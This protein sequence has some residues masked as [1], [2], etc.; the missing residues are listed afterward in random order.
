MANELRSG[1]RRR[2]VMGLAGLL[3]PA[4]AAPLF[5]GVSVVREVMPVAK[6]QGGEWEEL[7]YEGNGLVGWSSGDACSCFGW[8]YRGS[9][10]PVSC[11]W[12]W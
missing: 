10:L 12:C 4:V 1:G 7:W 9:G 3:V 11:G 5:Q 6:L 8:S 2:F